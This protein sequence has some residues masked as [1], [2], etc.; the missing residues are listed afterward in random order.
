MTSRGYNKMTALTPSMSTKT[1]IV[2]SMAWAVFIFCQQAMVSMK[3][4]FQDEEADLDAIKETGLG[5]DET[6]LYGVC[7]ICCIKGPSAIC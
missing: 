6:A 5:A 4:D 1:A 2:S 3:G 7:T